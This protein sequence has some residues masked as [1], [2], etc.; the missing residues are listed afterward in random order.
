MPTPLPKAPPPAKAEKRALISDNSRFT[1]PLAC[2][3]N[4]WIGPRIESR[5]TLNRLL[6]RAAPISSRLA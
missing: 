6:A 5:I 4:L 1:T 3:T 2:P